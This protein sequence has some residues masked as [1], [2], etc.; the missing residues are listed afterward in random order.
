[1]EITALHHAI[2]ETGRRAIQAGLAKASS[3]NISAREPGSDRFLITASGDA[4]DELAPDRLVWMDIEGKTLSEGGRPS[5]E[6]Q[7]HVAIYRRCPEINAIVHL[8]PPMATLVGTVFGQVRPVTFE[9]YHYL[10]DVGIVP[11]ILP[12]TQELALAAAEVASESRALILQHHGAV[13]IGEDLKEALYRS[14]E[15]EETCRLI[16]WARAMRV[17]ASLPGWAMERMRGHLY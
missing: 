13:C 15:L 2:C 3:G 17:D 10:G 6:Y 9:G 8:H 7:L 12:G 5:S 11:P 1:M 16:V 4:L 14:I